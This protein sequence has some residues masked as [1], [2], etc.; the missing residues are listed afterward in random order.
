VLHSPVTFRSYTG[1]EAV[2]T[3]LRL[4]AET[5]EDMRYTDELHG[6]DGVEVL[7][8]RARVGDRKIEGVDMLRTGADGLIADRGNP[9]TTISATVDGPRPSRRCRCSGTGWRTRGPRAVLASFGR[10]G[11]FATCRGRAEPTVPDRAS[12]CGPHAPCAA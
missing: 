1:R 4:I 8:L 12:G 5:F 2:G 7:V 3:L 6:P 10:A 9:T 11:A